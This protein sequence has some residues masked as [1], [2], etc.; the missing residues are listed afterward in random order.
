MGLEPGTRLGPYEIVTLAGAGGM[1]EVYRAR[2]T[3][4]GRSVAIKIIGPAYGHQPEIRRRFESEARLAAQLDHPRIGAVFDVGHDEGVDYFVMEFIEGRTLADR[5]AGRPLAFAELIGYAIEIAAGLAYAHTRGVEHR[6]LKPRNILLTQSGVKIIDF[7]IGKL[8][9]SE[10]RPSVDMASM[11]TLPLQGLA[12]EP[13]VPGTTA[14]LPP[15]RLQGR[16]GDHRSDIFAFGAVLYEMATGRRAF[17]GPT[18]ADL[19]SEILTAEPPALASAEGPLAE[20]DWVIRRCLKKA[21][22]DRWQSMADVEAVLKR[23]ASAS[24]KRGTHA[25]PDAPL[26]GSWIVAAAILILTIAGI[27]FF[28]RRGSEPGTA[29]EPPVAFTVLPAPASGFTPSES[30]VQSHQLAVSPDGRYLAFIATGVD[31]VSQIW[32]RPI[33]ETIGRPVP[34]TVGATYPFWSASSRS[35]GFFS[36]EQLKRIDLDR[37]PARSL[38]AAPAGSGGSWSGDDIILFSPNRDSEIYSISGD[39]EVRRQTALSTARKEIS[40]R[41]PQFLPDRRHFIYFANSADD[42][43]SGIRLASLDAS[44]EEVIVPTQFG[45]MYIPSGHLLYVSEHALL[46]A[47]F[48]VATGRLADDP[49][50]VVDRIATSSNF[51]GA[52]CASNNGVLAYATAVP[53]AELAWIGRDG[54]SRGIAAPFGRYGDFK[55]SPDNRLLAV[56]EVDQQSDRSDL[57]L[58]DLLRRSNPR[59]TT[60]PATDASPVWSPD[61]SRLAFR[62]NREGPHD[63]FIRPA[64]VGGADEIFVK[65]GAANYPTDWSPD[66]ESIVFHAFNKDTK[67]DVWVAPVRHADQRRTLVASKYDD[68]QGQMSPSGRWLAYTSNR[69]SRYEV[70]VESLQ[71]DAGLWQVSVDGGSD[72]E[73]RADEKELFF[74]SSDGQMMSVDLTGGASF[75]RVVPRALFRFRT[76]AVMSPF[77]SAYDVDRDG[78]RFLVRTKETL[79]THPLN[80]VVHWSVPGQAAK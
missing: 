74:V 8:R 76:I 80:V 75:D 45:A 36:D 67:Y 20:V 35:L 12:P 63:L 24:S 69:S 78:E 56:A 4:L 29:P 2:D 13:A 3:R 64:S 41:W 58:R 43:Q 32:V 42:A 59:L 77:L 26:K 38:A 18:P 23:I 55:L 10:R 25:V 33:G 21:P 57:R 61:G 47:S 68:V 28:A 65:S 16:P 19:V 79:E 34:G 49:V 50:M 14:Y 37:G 72:P 5:I 31:G 52:F 46:A 66:G 22:E 40:H 1:G 39:G 11:K 53:P 62:S 51:Y 44:G 7:G 73:W 30:T 71:P 15:E 9:Q 48:D 60:S 6:D 54:R 70:Y 27:A 17:D